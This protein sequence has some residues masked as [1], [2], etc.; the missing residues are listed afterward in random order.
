MKKTFL[1][2][3]LIIGLLVGCSDQA[4]VEM[5]D[6]IQFE[7]NED[8]VGIPHPEIEL[9]MKLTEE[10]RLEFEQIQKEILSKVEGE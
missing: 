7:P 10:E 5:K 2:L 9:E 3:I 6:Q 8:Y 1:F 4:D